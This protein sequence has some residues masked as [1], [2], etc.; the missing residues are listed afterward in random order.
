[1]FSVATVFLLLASLVAAGLRG[2]RAA[3]APPARHARL[4]SGEPPEAPPP[5]AAG[6]RRRR[7]GD[8]RAG[9]NDRRPRAVGR[10]RPELESA[11]D[12]RIDRL[13]LPWGLIVGRRSVLVGGHRGRAWWPG[14]AVARLPRRARSRRDR[15]GRGR[16]ATRPSRR[17]PGRRCRGWPRCSTLSTTMPTRRSSAAPSPSSPGSCS[18]ARWRSAPRHRRPGDSRSPRDWPLRDLARYQARSG[19]ALA[20]ITLGLGIAVATM[21]IAGANVRPADAGNL[22]DRE[23]IVRV[24]SPHTELPVHTAAEIAGM[25]TAV[26]RLAAGLDHAEVVSLEAA[27]GTGP[28]ETQAGRAVR[29]P[30]LLARQVGPHTWRDVGGDLFVATPGVLRH[31]GVDAASVS[32]A[33]E[34][35]TASSCEHPRHPARRPQQEPPPAHAPGAGPPGVVGLF[36]RAAV[37][38]HGRRHAPQRPGG[39]AG[40]LAGLVDRAAH[41]RPDRR[42]PGDRR[43]GGPGHR[44]RATASTPWP[45]PGRWPPRSGCCSPCA[46]WR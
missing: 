33:T 17:R 6:Q 9:G 28:V 45:S 26:R 43:R 27:V 4:R 5:R 22:S 18:S 16:P 23:V 40:R 31:L 32:P 7:R 41:R 12:H 44:G 42:R 29:P 34:V 38:H 35:L 36:V 8:R 2:R 37:L 3:T 46:C 39:R 25:R 19:A 1:M 10:L 21:A 15:P 14:R 20:A 13:G 30:A 11:V 24:G